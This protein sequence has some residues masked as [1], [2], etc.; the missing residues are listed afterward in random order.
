MKYLF[1][2]G[3]LLTGCG[4][5]AQRA[6]Q[7]DGFSLVTAHQNH[8]DLWD[9]ADMTLVDELV[10]RGGLTVEDREAYARG[11]RAAPDPKILWGHPTGWSYGWEQMGYT[12]KE[13][14]AYFST[15]P[16]SGE[17]HTIYTPRGS[18]TVRSFGGVITAR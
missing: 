7:M 12:E 3:L 15:M 6:Q 18:T 16:S 9:R 4:V 14:R 10:A 1:L 8:I 17:R 2:I 13:V 11:A 5:S